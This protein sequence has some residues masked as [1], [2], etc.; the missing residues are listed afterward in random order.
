MTSQL[1]LRKVAS[2][3]I[4]AA[5]E[6]YEAQRETLG[7]EFLEDIE[8]TLQ[9]IVEGPLRFPIVLGVARKA[10][11]QRFPY[12]VFFRIRGTVVRVDGVFHQNRDPRSWKRRLS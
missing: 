11:L 1:K 9:R 8:Q 5:Y 6:W 4:E 2:A 12:T 3:D 7:R 10:L